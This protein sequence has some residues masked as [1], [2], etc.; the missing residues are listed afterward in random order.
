MSSSAI[1]DKRVALIIGNSA[2]R[3]VAQLPNPEK[4]ATAIA[5]LFRDA[6]FETVV[7]ENNAGN[8]DF[9]RAIRNFEDAAINSDIAVVFYAGHGIEIGGV[10]YLIPI[11]AKLASDRDAQDEA[12]PLD[13][14]VQSVEG[15]KRLHLIILDACRDNPFG[16][17]MK[18]MIASRSM[19]P[20]LAKVEPEGTD[21]L[22]AYAAKAGSTAEDG[23]GNHSPFTTALLANLITPGLDIRLALGRVRD[24]VMKMT[25][26]RQEPFVYGS[27]GGSIVS[28]VPPAEAKRI[29]PVPQPVAPTANLSRDYEFA[30]QIGT[31][32]AWDSFLATYS[33]GFYANLARAARDKLIATEQNRLQMVEEAR[34]KAEDQA[35]LKAGEEA[36]AKVAKIDRPTAPTVVAMAPPQPVIEPSSK[37]TMPPVDAADLA[38][39]LQ[40]HLKRV[41]CDPGAIEGNWGDGA[42]HALEQFNSHAGTKFDVKVASVDALEVVKAQKGRICPLVCGIGYRIVN[43]RCE[44]EPRETSRPKKTPGA[45][46]SVEQSGKAV[47]GEDGQVFCSEK[48]GCTAVPKNCR[49]VNTSI[50]SGH[51]GGQ[52][53][54][55]N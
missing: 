8:L 33:I 17:K 53:V 45:G 23:D 27:L 15:A 4:D 52:S 25:N 54:T 26:G 24:Q 50:L 31:K 22:I 47:K 11:D 16:K 38:R 18:R 28:L 5:K 14:L 51:I 49:I 37:L 21:T 44:R 20:G 19:S 1:A 35:R 10:N 34:R 3:N 40:Y 55:C 46:R 39:L 2:Y 30:A 32:E 41:G 9:K 36:K 48:T 12:I 13:R 42:R 43:D 6:G 29:E 7:T